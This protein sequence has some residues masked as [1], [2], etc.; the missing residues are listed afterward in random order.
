[1]HEEILAFANFQFEVLE[2]TMKVIV[3]EGVR[4][5]I[6]YKL[7][8]TQFLDRLREAGLQ[9]N[10]DDRPFFS[11]YQMP[12][13]DDQFFRQFLGFQDEIK[14]LLATISE[15]RAIPL[16]AWEAVF[17]EAER[18]GEVVVPHPP[19]KKDITEQDLGR[20]AFQKS[21]TAESYR[22]LLYGQLRGLII[23]RR[24]FRLRKCLECGTFFLDDTRRGNKRYCSA[25]TCANRAKQRAFLLRNMGRRAKAAANQGL[26][27]FPEIAA[28]SSA[29]G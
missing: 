2:T 29:G 15:R 10:P 9:L 20:L 7:N 26:L 14:S 13:P 27:A 22:A 28:G 23:S 5:E 17:R 16:A 21:I 19:V 3:G 6:R 18:V 25:A 12:R 4:D 1:M 24:I 8:W 11:R